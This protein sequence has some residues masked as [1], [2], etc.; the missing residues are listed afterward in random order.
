MEEVDEIHSSQLYEEN[1]GVEQF[2][3]NILRIMATD[4]NSCYLLQKGCRYQH[5]HVYWIIS[6]SSFK[7]SGT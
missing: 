3:N 1:K 4:M 7:G 6:S 2:Y 5:K